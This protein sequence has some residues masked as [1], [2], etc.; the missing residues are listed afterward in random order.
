MVLTMVSYIIDRN[1]ESKVMKTLDDDAF[2]GG[3][4][5][6]R[7]GV[8]FGSIFWAKKIAARLSP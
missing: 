4:S 8:K 7:V 5:G 6:G 3:N 1:T 2:R